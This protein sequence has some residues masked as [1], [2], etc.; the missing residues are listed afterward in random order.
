MS[1]A[2]RWTW[3]AA[4]AVAATA[5]LAD[6]ASA[7]PVCTATKL[8][9]AG[10]DSGAKLRCHA[11]A[12]KA[13]AA[14]DPACLSKSSD[15]LALS[16]S[17]AE[18]AGGCANS[19]DAV[20][21]E[22][23]IDGQVADVVA[24]IPLG[25]DDASRA[26]A[27][28]KLTAAGKKSKLRLTCYSKAEK[29][30]VDV[31][32]ACL[33]KAEDKFVAAF[34]KAEAAGGCASMGDAAAIEALV[35]IG[36][37]N[38]LAEVLPTCGDNFISGT[39]QCDGTDDAACP[40]ECLSSCICPGDCG[41]GVAEIGEECDDGGNTSGD[42]CRDDC[43]LED[44][45]AL[46]AGVA[47]VAGTT[48]DKVLVDTF[49]SP[50]LV[51][52]PTLDPRRLFVVEQDG[53]IRIVKDGAT[54][55]TPFLNIDS[56]VASGGERGLLGLA[57]HPD[58]E[59]N[60]RFFVNYTNN[61]G[62]TVIARYE[63]SVGDPDVADV[64]SEEILLTITQ[65]FSNHNGGMV[66]FGPDGYL[67]V[68]M[69]DGGSGG[70]PN[71]NAQDDGELLG[72][73]LRI[74]VDVEVAPFH[75][76]PPD[77]PN[78]GA[79]LPL[80]LIWSK[81]LRNPWRFSFDRGTGDLYIGDVGQGAVEEI[82]Y[83]PASSTGGVNWG[84]DIFE[85][86]ACFEPDPDPDCPDPPTGFTFPVHEYSHLLGCSVTGGY[87]YRGCTLPDLAGRYFYSDYCSPFV[88]TFV[89]SGGA[90]T[91]FVDKTGEL[92]A[93]L[94]SISSYGEDARGEV[95]IVSL[96]GAVWKIVPN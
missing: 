5:L 52:A 68:G 72:K 96:D 30:N 24:A 42:G 11:K 46:C 88:D 82:D 23:R 38:I 6:G 48:L 50:V 18:T 31:D 59:S 92:G 60:G 64:G 67:Y 70:D 53:F 4:S 51:T 79:G 93:G 25:G 39:E 40:G 65:P 26:C 41:N 87:V 84:W 49:T 22:A 35:D 33:Q 15:K 75:A 73:M 44:A 54:L 80:G 34:G 43:V 83:E 94:A 28:K 69:G 63:V 86:S 85:G 78:A 14:V 17:K 77:N 90:A 9:A 1:R 7:A 56:K 57:F 19:G 21:V 95:Y 58:Y 91:S 74:D 16:F 45:S 89:I 29:K 10:K 12:A 2:R 66:A 55:P 32:P 81:G 62:H 27:Y 61:G 3:L 8:K 71:E 47:T 76:V 20:A 37:A 36:V 13:N